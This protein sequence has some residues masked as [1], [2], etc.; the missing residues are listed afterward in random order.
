M[1]AADHKEKRQNEGAREHVSQWYNGTCWRGVEVGK[2]R[3][4]EIGGEGWEG[5]GKEAGKGP[6]W[7]SVHSQA[8]D[9]SAAGCVR[10][11]AQKYDQRK[12]F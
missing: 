3:E 7:Q 11:A 6:G 4:R 9:V 10:P 1:S 5:T 8:G 12:R 2:E